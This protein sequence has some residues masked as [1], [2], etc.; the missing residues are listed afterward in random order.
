MNEI[1]SVIQGPDDGTGRPKAWIVRG[2]AFVEMRKSVRAAKW[3]ATR[4]NKGLSSPDEDKM[5]PDQIRDMEEDQP[6]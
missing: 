1:Y 3:V 2:G 4:M 6:E 5:T